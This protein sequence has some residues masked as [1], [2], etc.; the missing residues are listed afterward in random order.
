MTASELQP[1]ALVHTEHQGAG[2]ACRSEACGSLKLHAPPFPRRFS[3]EAREEMR[4][5]RMLR[6]LLP[7]CCAC[8]LR[9]QTAMQ[10]LDVSHPG[11]TGLAPKGL[12]SGAFRG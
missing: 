11:H 5:L 1:A 7:L 2:E 9:R 8:Q 4:L 3:H 10:A 6:L 12:Q